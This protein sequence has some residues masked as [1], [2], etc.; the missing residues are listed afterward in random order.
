MALLRGVDDISASAD[1]LHRSLF[2]G[3]G[4]VAWT[5]VTEIR[6]APGKP[7]RLVI[8]GASSRTIFEGQMP[9]Q[10]EVGQ[11][12]T[13]HRAALAQARPGDTPDE[14]GSGVHVRD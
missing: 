9:T 6:P 5:D 10:D 11:L 4:H 7:E 1:G 13:W 14:N 12:H 2:H 8:R 3:R